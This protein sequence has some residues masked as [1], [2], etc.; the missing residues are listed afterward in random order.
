M[1]TTCAAGSDYSPTVGFIPTQ[2][3]PDQN[4]S[5]INQENKEPNNSPL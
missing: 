3:R 2:F 4:I 5:A 1:S